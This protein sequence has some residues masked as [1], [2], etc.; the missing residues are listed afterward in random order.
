MFYLRNRFALEV[1]CASYFTGLISVV[2]VNKS[3]A[4]S[5]NDLP[6]YDWPTDSDIL[7]NKSLSVRIYFYSN[8]QIKNTNELSIV[9]NDSVI[10]SRLSEFPAT[11]VQTETRILCTFWT[12]SSCEDDVTPSIVTDDVMKIKLVIKWRHVGPCPVC[13]VIYQPINHWV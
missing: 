7:S 4:W 12:S 13:A 1:I 11:L 5:A 10:L 8:T 3:W 2:K 6:T 9:Y